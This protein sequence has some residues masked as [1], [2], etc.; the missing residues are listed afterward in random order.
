MNVL[1]S[2][3]Q[4]TVVNRKNCTPSHGSYRSKIIKIKCLPYLHN[5]NRGTDNATHMSTFL[6]FINFTMEF[7]LF[8]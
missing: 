3:V 6:Y 1:L 5:L 2:K 8:K 4:F 7:M